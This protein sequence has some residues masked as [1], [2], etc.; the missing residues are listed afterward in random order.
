MPEPGHPERPATQPET[1]V[2]AQERPRDLPA[3]VEVA[4][5]ARVSENVSLTTSRLV[6]RASATP[7]SSASSL[8]LLLVHFHH[9]YIYIFRFFSRKSLFI[10]ETLNYTLEDP[11]GM[12]LYFVY[13]SIKRKKTE[14]PGSDQHRQ[15]IRPH[16]CRRPRRVSPSHM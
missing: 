16:R 6:V 11:I 14:H 5:G 12:S 7:L 9:V 8:F 3:N 4:A 2:K 15:R 13:F 10:L 1:L